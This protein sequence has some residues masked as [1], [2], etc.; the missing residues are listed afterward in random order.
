MDTYGQ[1]LMNM[2][3]V[4]KEICST[5]VFTKLPSKDQVHLQIN[6]PALDMILKATT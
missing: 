3:Q 6:V 2:Q 1:S 4:F 5:A